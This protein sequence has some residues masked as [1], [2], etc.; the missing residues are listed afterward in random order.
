LAPKNKNKAKAKAGGFSRF[1][2]LEAQNKIEKQKQKI[3]SS[4]V[5]TL[6]NKKR[7]QLHIT[8]PAST[9]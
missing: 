3:R 7:D 6:F 1:V 8:I 5:Q 2:C 9:V 4:Q